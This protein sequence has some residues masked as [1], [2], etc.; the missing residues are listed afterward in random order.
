MDYRVYHAVNRFVFHHAWLGRALADI[1]K[2]A[3]PVVAVATFALWLL[4]RPGGSSKWKL[5]SASAL[6]SAALALLVNQL[7]AKLWHRARP[8][9][10]HP[11]AHVWGGRSHDPSFPSDHSSA[12]FAIA[13]AILLFDRGAGLLFLAVA[14]LIG[15]G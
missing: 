8:F 4:A 3:V 6:A 12:A 5:A 7:I 10:T 1:E 11:S 14:V 13:F 9:E 15:G 2:W